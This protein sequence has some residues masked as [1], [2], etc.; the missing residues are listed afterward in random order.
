MV[1]KS[2]EISGLGDACHYLHQMLTE[3]EDWQLDF[4]NIEGALL[5]TFENDEE[6]L[7]AL[8]DVEDTYQMVC[9]AMDMALMMG[10]EF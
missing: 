8:E 10:N 6:T 9:E 3:T 4:Y 1:H 5:M 2:H 7:Q